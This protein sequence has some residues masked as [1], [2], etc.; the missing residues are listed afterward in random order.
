M[1]YKRVKR[2]YQEAR[3]HVR[4]RRRKKVLLGERPPLLRPEAANQV[5]S[6]DFMFARTAEGRV[7]KAL[8]I[9]DDATHEAVAIEVERAISGHGVARVLDRLALTPGLPLVIRI[10]NGKE[11]CGK[12]MVTG[13]S[14]A[15]S[16]AAL[17]PARQAEPERL[18][19]E[20]Q[21]P[22]ARR[23]LQRALVPDPAARLHR[24]R[25][26]ATGIQRGATEEDFGRP[27]PD[28]QCPT[29][30]GQSRYDETRV[31]KSPATE[32]G[33]TSSK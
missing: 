8:T 31:L 29:A 7:L 13:G 15:R 3:L 30:S 17:D 19:R 6:M 4:R 10:D 24:D 11:F 1:S 12:T 5:W 25:D 27:D 26:L 2:L 16:A 9:V 20:L 23:M 28:R 21:R 18:H 14:R 22:P 32:S 33:G